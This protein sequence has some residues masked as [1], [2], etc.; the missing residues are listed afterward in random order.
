MAFRVELTTRAARDLRRLFR[1]INADI[2]AE[3]AAWFNGLE[4]TILGLSG[5][6]E[7]GMQTAETRD[8]R[9]VL[10]SSGC[11]TY[12]IIYSIDKRPSVV[13]IVQ[14]RHGARAAMRV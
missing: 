10:Y 4:T 11:N 5:L 9:Q 7:R 1:K 14:V 6:P 2:A 12:R 13:S 8:L 3:A